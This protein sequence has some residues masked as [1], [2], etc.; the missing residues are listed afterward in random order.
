[1]DEGLGQRRHA[2]RGRGGGLGLG[3][4]AE[5]D[6]EL[7]RVPLQIR[8]PVAHAGEHVVGHVRERRFHQVEAHLHQKAKRLADAP[9]QRCVGQLRQGGEGAEQSR[10][11]LQELRRLAGNQVVHARER[12]GLQVRQAAAHAV[13]QK[14][15][16]PCERIGRARRGLAEQ[17]PAVLRDAHQ[18]FQRTPLPRVRPLLQPEEQRADDRGRLLREERRDAAGRCSSGGGAVGLER[19][20]DA[21]SEVVIPK[22]RAVTRPLRALKQEETCQLAVR[23]E[24]GAAR[25]LS[26]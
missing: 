10:A 1:M 24:R 17:V 4:F 2:R 21:R 22:L 19:V 5:Y 3:C 9:A 16:Q 11:G 25:G 23:L 12:P 14:G 8:I 7:A 20:K 6:P 15:H 18:R 26:G 13:Q